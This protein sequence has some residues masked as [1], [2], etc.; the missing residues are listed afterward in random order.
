MQCVEFDPLNMQIRM[1]GFVNWKKN[2]T[3][4][5]KK[6]EQSKCTKDAV[7][8]TVILPGTKYLWYAFFTSLEIK[9]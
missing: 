5:L 6:P 9:L 3:V 8:L 4:G 1:P 2:A 7:Q